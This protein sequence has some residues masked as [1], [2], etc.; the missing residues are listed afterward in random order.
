MHSVVPA[1]QHR[2]R[3][4]V[5]RVVAVVV[6]LVLVFGLVQFATLVGER[7]PDMWRLD[8]NPWM[9]LGG[10]PTGLSGSVVGAESYSLEPGYLRLAIQSTSG[11]AHPVILNRF[12]ALWIEGDIAS[13]ATTHGEFI[14][15]FAGLRATVVGI[16]RPAFVPGEPGEIYA[17][18]VVVTGR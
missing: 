4:R 1:A 8:A 14:P 11:S 2:W 18:A 13:A 16:E 3:G 10:R 12:A 15:G 7:D 5:G 17:I 9:M 6:A